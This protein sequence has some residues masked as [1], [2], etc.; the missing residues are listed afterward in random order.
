MSRHAWHRFIHS[1]NS[2][3]SALCWALCKV[4]ENKGLDVSSSG[5][6]QEGVTGE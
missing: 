6:T 3:W 5:Y 1:L 2:F 4:W